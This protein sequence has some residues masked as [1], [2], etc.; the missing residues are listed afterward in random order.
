MN[1]APLNPFKPRETRCPRT[2][3]VYVPVIV[4]GRPEDVP[5]LIEWPLTAAGP[6]PDT[7][8]PGSPVA[9]NSGGRE[10]L[11]MLAVRRGRPYIYVVMRGVACNEVAGVVV[12]DVWFSALLSSSSWACRGVQKGGG[13]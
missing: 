9:D 8:S 5:G 13:K 7:Y 11:F 6:L 10:T 4:P 2:S 12:K 3:A 1:E